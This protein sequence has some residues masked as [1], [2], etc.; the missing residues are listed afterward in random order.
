MSDLLALPAEDSEVRSEE[1]AR[2]GHEGAFEDLPEPPP[3]RE[4]GVFLHG[5]HDTLP[6]A[7]KAVEFPDGRG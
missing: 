3:G 1:S 4:P 6:Y 7:G 5:A 2:A